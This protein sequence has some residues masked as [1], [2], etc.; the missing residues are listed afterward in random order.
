MD[1][2]SYPNFIIIGAAKCGTTSLADMLQLHPDVFVSSPKEPHYF[3]FGWEN[4][5]REYE[6]LFRGTMRPFKGEASTTYTQG[7]YEY[8]VPHRIHQTIPDVR[9]IYLLRNPV[10]RIRSQY[11]H[12]VD[13]GREDRPI[14]E[15]VR[16]DPSYIEHTRYG[17]HLETFLQF[18]P[19]SQI[20]WLRTSS[21]AMSLAPSSPRP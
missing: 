5:R 12:R 17:Y 4:R 11:I 18:F 6:A 1:H 3:T 2:D 15:A 7:P 14:E 13:R 10:E 21:C 20:L 19:R 16:E 9:L 8:S